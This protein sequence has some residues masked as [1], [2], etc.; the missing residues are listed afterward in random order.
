MI[1]L[2]RIE[3]LTFFRNEP[4]LWVGGVWLLIFDASPFGLF[5]MD[6]EEDEYCQ[7]DKHQGSTSCNHSNDVCGACEPWTDWW[8]SSWLRGWIFWGGIGRCAGWGWWNTIEW[9]S[10]IPSTEEFKRVYQQKNANNELKYESDL[11]IESKFKAAWMWKSY[12]KVWGL[13]PAGRLPVNWLFSMLLFW[14]KECQRFSQLFYINRNQTG[15]ADVAC[16][17][18]VQP[19]GGGDIHR[20]DWQCLQ[21]C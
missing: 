15:S 14:A 17:T 11:Q 8:T 9:I 21:V 10:S 1:S 19:N 16:K 12:R 6:T 2:L 7:N 3:I 5:P 4:C 20:S 18:L 13:N